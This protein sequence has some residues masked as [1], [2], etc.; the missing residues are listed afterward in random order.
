MDEMN[1]DAARGEAL[2]RVLERVTAWQETAPEGTIGTELDRA[3]REAG[4]T[5][6][7]DQR[8]LVIGQVSAG[9]RVDIE[10]LQPRTGEGG[11]A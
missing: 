5:L 6:T 7:D 11:P 9:E 4:V 10:M 8:E 1:Q 3:L 2:R